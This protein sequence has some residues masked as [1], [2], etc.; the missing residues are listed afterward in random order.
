MVEKKDLDLPNHLMGP[1]RRYL[2]LHFASVEDLIK[3]KQ[4]V[5]GTIRK[6]REKEKTSSTY[7]PALFTRW[8]PYYRHISVLWVG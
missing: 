6:N 1:K 2:M 4:E 3:A 8:F 7:N 5:M